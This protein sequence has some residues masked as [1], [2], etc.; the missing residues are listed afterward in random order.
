ML[1]MIYL[2]PIESLENIYD[3]MPATVYTSLVYMSRLVYVIG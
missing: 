2:V 3:S 1:I